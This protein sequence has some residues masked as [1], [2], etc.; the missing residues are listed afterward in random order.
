MPHGSGAPFLFSPPVR[1]RPA[2]SPAHFRQQRYG[3]TA[4]R[5]RKRQDVAESYFS[6]PLI[7]N[8][9]RQT[10]RAWCLL[11]RM[12]VCYTQDCRLLTPDT[13]KQKKSVFCAINMPSCKAKHAVFRPERPALSTRNMACFKIQNPLYPASTLALKPFLPQPCPLGVG[14]CQ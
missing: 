10:P 1:W 8:D 4:D 9:L 13:P 11:L 14:G 7:L 3:K 2:L 6:T 5:A 12:P